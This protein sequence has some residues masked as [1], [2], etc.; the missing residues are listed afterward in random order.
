M[1][2]ERAHTFR[3]TDDVPHIANIGRA[4]AVQ[5]RLRPIELHHSIGERHVVGPY[6]LA[7]G[8]VPLGEDGTIRVHPELEGAGV[9]LNEDGLWWRAEVYYASRGEAEKVSALWALGK[10][11]LEE[12][13]G[14]NAYTAR[15][16]PRRTCWP[17]RPRLHA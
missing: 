5:Q 12:V 11:V 8:H 3:E 7:K 10:R 4:D 13:R 9:E 17:A 15:S 1:D 16:T 6:G 2:Y 14:F